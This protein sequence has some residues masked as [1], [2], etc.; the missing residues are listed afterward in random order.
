MYLVDFRDV[1]LEKAKRQSAIKELEVHAH[2]HCIHLG[3]ISYA[4]GWCFA[5]REMFQVSFGTDCMCRNNCPYCFFGSHDEENIQGYLDNLNHLFALS[6]QPHWKPDIISYNS[7]GETLQALTNGYEDLFLKAALIV[8]RVEER[9]AYKAY[10]KI[11]TNGVL[12]DKETLAF[13]KRELDINEIRFHLS[14]SHFSE[15]VYHNM[16]VASEMGFVVVV[17]EPSLL[18][19][20][21]KLFD[22]LFKIERIGVKHLDICE[23]EITH[24]NI[25]RLHALFPRGR[26]Y[27]N[28]AYHLYDEGLVYDLMEEVIDKKYS[29]SVIDCNSDRERFARSQ[30]DEALPLEDLEGVFAAP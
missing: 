18:S 26:M 1:L 21:E 29:F 7:Y 6:S 25:Q 19:N 4:C 17:E 3:R 11:Y 8:T 15:N 30:R 27:K 13:L 5:R 23:V 22:M 28:R 2:G 16:Q 12:A 24:S 14:A 10:K 20:R 9:H